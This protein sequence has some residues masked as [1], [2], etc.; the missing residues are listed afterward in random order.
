MD[1]RP[2][3]SQRGEGW[4]PTLTTDYHVP[5][6]FGRVNLQAAHVDL[7]DGTQGGAVIHLDPAQLQ[8]IG[9]IRP[10]PVMLPQGSSEAVH[11]VEGPLPH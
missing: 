4:S 10:E 6:R 7:A 5:A 3:G 1:A 8:R 11:R 9:P 2:G